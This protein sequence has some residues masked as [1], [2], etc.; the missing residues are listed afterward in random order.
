MKSTL[1]SLRLPPKLLSLTTGK[2]TEEVELQLESTE[3]QG[4]IDQVIARVGKAKFTSQDDAKVVPGLYKDF[5]EKITSTL[6]NTLAL[7]DET[8]DDSAAHSGTSATVAVAPLHPADGQLLLL[9]DT[10]SRRDA[11]IEGTLKVCQAEGQRLRLALAQDEVGEPTFDGCSQR[12]LPWRPP[13]AAERNTLVRLVDALR[14]LN[15][16]SLRASK[17]A[18]KKASAGAAGVLQTISDQASPPLAE[19]IRR[20]AQ[21]LRRQK[22]PM[23]IEQLNRVAVPLVRAAG[24]TGWRNYAS[25]SVL[26]IRRAAGEWVDAEV[27]G[28]EGQSSVVH[29]L[30]LENTASGQASFTPMED[31]GS[32]SS[33]RHTPRPSTPPTAE[34]SSSTV[35]VGATVRV[36]GLDPD[37]FGMNGLVGTVVSWNDKHRLWKV[38]IEG[39]A[40][41]YGLGQKSLQVIGA[42]HLGTPSQKEHASQAGEAPEATQKKALRFQGGAELSLEL[43]PWNHTLS[44]LPSTKFQEA[45]DEWKTSLRKEYAHISDAV[46]GR[47]LDVLEQCVTI[48]VAGDAADLARVKDAGG[49]SAWLHQLHQQRCRGTEAPDPTA[50]LL[51][52]PPAAGKVSD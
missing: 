15:A 14:D 47:P 8:Q 45:L 38:Q 36:V 20:A 13:T 21:E 30:R 43:H 2:E 22:G 25:G 18:A 41:A 16:Q 7:A 17:S 6:Q 19:E 29:Q 34:R 27:I 44:E 39:R 1:D 23:T 42:P 10:A 51:T 28:T 4:R 48:D 24:A 5:V 32:P 50:A 12:V 3:L 37:K 46:L 35:A 11:G 52:G 9:P 33:P 40:K 31:L 49:L 26:V